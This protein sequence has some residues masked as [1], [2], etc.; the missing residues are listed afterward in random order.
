[1]ESGALLNDIK[2]YVYLKVRLLF[3]PPSSSSVSDSMRNM[4][5]E[6]EWRINVEG[7]NSIEE[8][9]NV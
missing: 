9:D 5:S 6:L 8:S 7:E 4:I 3:D 2:S 1:M